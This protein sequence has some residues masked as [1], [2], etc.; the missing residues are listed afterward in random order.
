MGHIAGIQGQMQ[1]L[2]STVFLQSVRL[3]G[4]EAVVEF[5]QLA[6][7]MERL[8]RMMCFQEKCIP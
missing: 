8:S 1:V 2:L 7:G 6:E 4:L 3:F 5:Y